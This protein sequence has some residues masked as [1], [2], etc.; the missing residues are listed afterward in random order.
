MSTPGPNQQPDR[1]VR[2]ESMAGEVLTSIRRIIRAIELHSRF[3]V[4]RYG[5][6]GPQ[7]A[8]LLELSR[9]DGVSVSRLSRGVHLSQATVTGILDRL[10][11]RRLIVR[12]RS[13]DDKRRVLVHLSRE[14]A[15]LLEQAPPALQES[16]LAQFRK[17]ADW[18]QTQIL[19]SLQ[20]VVAMMEARHLDASALLATGPV[21]ATPE[22]T[23]MFL[24]DGDKEP[25]P[26]LTGPAEGEQ[27]RREA[28]GPPT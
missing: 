25:R 9:H 5:L 18:E 14:G 8:V 15:E 3:L 4:D 28:S 19:S 11:K 20:R 16:F 1:D 21:T 13:S 27:P 24:D 26:S 22:T 23:R 17:L 12:E 10:E 7:L 2:S 6:T